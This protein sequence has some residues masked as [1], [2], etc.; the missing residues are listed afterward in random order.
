MQQQK[1]RGRKPKEMQITGAIS[2]AIQAAGGPVNVAAAFAIG[3]QMT[4]EHW[5]NGRC[6]TSKHI[7]KLA[8]LSGGAVTCEEICREIAEFK[9]VK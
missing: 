3:V 8:D 5:P 4:R 1:K 2:R 6:I 9:G 7:A